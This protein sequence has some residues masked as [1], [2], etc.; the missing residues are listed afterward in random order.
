LSWSVRAEAERLC[1]DVGGGHGGINESAG[2]CRC[3]AIAQGI[4]A[5]IQQAGR[6]VIAVEIELEDDPQVVVRA[7]CGA[8]VR[9][10]LETSPVLSE[11]QAPV[12]TVV[13]GSHEAKGV[14][15]CVC[16]S[17]AWADGHV[18]PDGNAC[19]HGARP[20][21]APAPPR[22]VQ[23]AA[24]DGALFALDGD[25]RIWARAAECDANGYWKGWRWEAMPPL[26]R[27][28]P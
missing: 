8:A 21:Y 19:P 26:P 27:S 12:A 6:A 28:T 24:A 7:Q 14:T 23:I 4:I 20:T 11:P 17:P 13:A 22:P 18:R 10:L 16:G 9:R 15:P 3:E 25:G 5:G 1:G 2:D